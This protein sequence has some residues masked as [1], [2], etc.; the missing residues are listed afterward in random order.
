MHWLA[1]DAV[2]Q[3]ARWNL[4]PV[5]C[6]ISADALPECHGVE[7]AGETMRRLRAAAVSPRGV[8]LWCSGA[9]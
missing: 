6:L 9:T 7:T 1:S 2:T 5:T 3:V 4:L 8:G